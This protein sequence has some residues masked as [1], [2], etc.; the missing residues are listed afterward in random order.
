MTDHIEVTDRIPRLRKD[1]FRSVGR[2][3]LSREDMLPIA[4]IASENRGGRALSRY[5]PWRASAVPGRDER[6]ASNRHY[7]TRHFENPTGFD[8]QNV[9]ARGDPR[10]EVNAAY[11]YPLIRK[12]S[13]YH[14][15]RGG[16][17]QAS[18][19]YNST[20]RWC[21]FRVGHRSAN[22]ASSTKGVSVS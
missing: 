11:Q 14:E 15:L 1:T 2:L 7:R 17:R 19:A 22:T 12:F 4:L 10:E 3:V 21:L 8:D 9:R 18:R 20:M 16:T 5:F 6:E 13:T